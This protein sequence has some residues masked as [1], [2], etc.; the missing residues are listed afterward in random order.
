MP[1]E[2]VSP[3]VT[4]A[5]RR[6]APRRTRGHGRHVEVGQAGAARSTKASSSDSGSTRGETARSSLHHPLA[7]LAVGVEAATE[8]RRVRAARPRLPGRH[9]RPDAVLAR[10]VGRRRHHA[11]AADP[12]DHHRL[13]AQRGLVALLDRGEEGVE[14]EVQHGRVGRM[15]ATYP[16]P[17]PPAG[18]APVSTAT[19]VGS[20]RIATAPEPSSSRLT[21]FRSSVLRQPREQRRPVARQPGV[22][23]ELVL[24][25]QSQLRQRQRELHAADE[26]PLARLPLELLDGLA[27][28]PAHELGVPVD[29]VQGARH[30]VLLRRVDRPGEGLRPR[31]ASLPVRRRR[32]PRRLH[33]LVGHPA[34]EEGVGLREVLDGVAMQLLVRGRSRGGRSTRPG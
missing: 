27:Q 5:T 26:Q 19:F 13:A 21:S 34:E 12:A 29:P 7:G 18:P 15:R 25:D 4:S 11:P 9:R 31:R 6:A 3:P 14:V 33:H 1:T 23:D 32:P 10:L 16:P 8:E 22:H 30:D 20:Y 2:A 28:V 17:P 24:V